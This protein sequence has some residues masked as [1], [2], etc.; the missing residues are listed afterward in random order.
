MWVP[1]RARRRSPDVVSA[2]LSRKP[3]ATPSR[4]L[5]RTV[6]AASPAMIAVPDASATY[7]A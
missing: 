6:M 1:S 3:G 7:T 4:T 2:M 5:W